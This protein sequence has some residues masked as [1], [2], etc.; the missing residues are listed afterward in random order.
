MIVRNKSLFRFRYLF[1]LLFA[2]LL[3]LFIRNLIS[4]L[5][6]PNTYLAGFLPGLHPDYFLNRLSGIEFLIIDFT[7]L[8]LLLVVA[9]IALSFWF[10][11]KTDRQKNQKMN[12]ENQ[13][14][15]IIIGYVYQDLLF[16]SE[17]LLNDRMLL[18]KSID[19]GKTREVFFVTIVH[20][21]DLV[22]EDLSGRLKNL[23]MELNAIKG[24]EYL[25]RSIKDGDAILGLRVVR[26]LNAKEFLPYVNYYIHSKNS[27][28]RIEAILTKL[29]ITVEAD[30]EE[31]FSSHSNLSSMDINRLLPEL[32]NQKQTPENLKHYIES[33]NSRINALGVILLKSKMDVSF[34][35]SVKKLLE[36]KDPFL[37]MVIWDYLTTVAEDS[38]EWFF[39]AHYWSESNANKIKILSALARLTPSEIWTNFLDKVIRKEESPFKVLALEA[40]FKQDAERFLHYMEQSDSP[41]EKAYDEVINLVN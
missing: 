1:G 29:R 15:P 17:T 31:L 13:V 34:K 6:L 8:T 10:D 41:I 21:Q 32:I 24:I 14:I 3:F 12:A 27:I 30:P 5:Q 22:D 25:L 35:K 40:I 38:D 23:C 33:S 28:L 37:R 11:R 2:V 19:D 20:F 18:K 9:F 36:K 26:T 39:T 16:I 7:L 4:Y